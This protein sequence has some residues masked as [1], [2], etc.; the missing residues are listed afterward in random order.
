MRKLMYAVLAVMFTL[1]GSAAMAAVQEYDTKIGK[2]AIDVP[3]GWNGAAVSEGCQLV[4]ADGKN[5]MSVQF[6]PADSR[7]PM[8]LA[9]QVAAAMK[10]D[11]AEETK[12]G[13]AVGLDGKMDGG[14]PAFVL[15]VKHEKLFLV[16]LMG[17]PDRETMKKIYDSV[18]GR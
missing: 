16:C 18:K 15:V 3:D 4:S 14:I 12:D 13:D 9:R 2:F 11:I 5:S 6:I 7:P 17:G 8:D 1:A 10:M